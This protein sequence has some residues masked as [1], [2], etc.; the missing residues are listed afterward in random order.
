[1]QGKKKTLVS[2]CLA[3][4]LALP[5]PTAAQAAENWHALPASGQGGAYIDGSSWLYGS[6]LVSN[7][8]GTLYVSMGV[9]ASL[10]ECAMPDIDWESGIVTYRIYNSESESY[11]TVLTVAAKDGQTQIYA[12]GSVIQWQHQPYWQE[13]IYAAEGALPNLMLPLREACQSVD[14]AVEYQDGIVFV[15]KRHQD[16]TVPDAASRRALLA[17]MTVSE[18]EAVDNPYSLMVNNG[19]IIASYDYTGPNWQAPH[20]GE[21]A[22]FLARAEDGGSLLVQEWQSDGT[23]KT[24]YTLPD[25]TSMAYFDNRVKR[26][27]TAAG[28]ALR[29]DFIDSAQSQYSTL[30]LIQPD[31]T[32]KPVLGSSL[33]GKAVLT[34]DQ[35]YYIQNWNFGGRSQLLNVSLAGGESSSRLDRADLSYQDIMI[36]D[37]DHLLIQAWLKEDKG[38]RLFVL[39]TVSGDYQPLTEQSWQEYAYGGDWVYGLDAEDNCIYRFHIDGSGLT[40][41]T[42][43]VSR[44][45]E[46]MLDGTVVLYVDEAGCLHLAGDQN[47]QLSQAPVQEWQVFGQQV[48]YRQSGAAAGIYVYDLSNDK[49]QC[50][51]AGEYRQI[52]VSAQGQLAAVPA[53]GKTIALWQ[54]GTWQVITPE[55]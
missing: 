20:K 34:Q 43:P 31:S 39:D 18:D 51:R 52:A 29:V 30:Y 24:L 2:L 55:K 1:M 16:L 3:A 13:S 45:G 19:Q 42:E 48:Y 53:G 36:L 47:K 32:L 54:D 38:K 5:L 9:F 41:L 40:Q 14:I 6:D 50:L 33:L 44:F 12:D 49:R 23:R 37:K 26:L 21:G 11:E 35:L 4:C 7:H 27:E 15:G 25:H 22:L 8:D 46:T 17:N 28:E 10:V